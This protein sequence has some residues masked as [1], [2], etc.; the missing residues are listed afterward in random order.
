[1][2]RRRLLRGGHVSDGLGGGYL[3]ALGGLLGLVF[4]RARSDIAGVRHRDAVRA[5]LLLRLAAGR[6]GAGVFIVGLVVI[7]V[8]VVLIARR[9]CGGVSNLGGFGVGAQRGE[10]VA[11]LGLFG[12]DHLQRSFA[13]GGL[14]V[15]CQ[16]GD[17]VIV[18]RHGGGVNGLDA[19]AF[20]GRTLDNQRSSQGRVFSFELGHVH[21]GF[22]VCLG[23]GLRRLRATAAIWLGWLTSRRTGLLGERVAALAGAVRDIVREVASG[24][25]RNKLVERGNVVHQASVHRLLALKDAAIGHVS[26][27]SVSRGATVARHVVDKNRIGIVNRILD[28]L[29]AILRQRRILRG[30]ALVFA[31]GD[32]GGLVARRRFGTTHIHV[33]GDHA[34]TADRRGLA[35]GIHPIGRAADPVSGA[36]HRAVRQ[37]DDRLAAARAENQVAQLLGAVHS[38]AGR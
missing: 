33:C 8:A 12:G 31:G 4:L 26:Q 3:A 35:G 9:R 1:M 24:C 7:L 6:A 17:Q 23:L 13:A 14:A 27:N 29:P 22:L 10:L 16:L 36:R 34:D 18:A 25:P 11:L 19:L 37:G 5:R 2:V 32:L 28:R 20:S 15:E 21:S 30:D 38:A